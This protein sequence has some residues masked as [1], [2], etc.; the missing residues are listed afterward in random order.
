M[1]SQDIQ[2]VKA[3]FLTDKQFNDKQSPAASE[4]WF[5]KLPHWLK[6]SNVN[7]LGITTQPTA[8]GNE[9][10]F[11]AG[12]AFVVHMGK[13]A[14]G[15]NKNQIVY[16]DSDKYT[17]VSA[18]G[19]Y[20]FD[21]NGNMVVGT[22]TYDPATNLVSVNG[23]AGNYTQ[24]VQEFTYSGGSVTLGDTITVGEIGGGGG[25]TYTTSGS[26]WCYDFGN[27]IVMQGGVAYYDWDYYCAVANFMVPMKNTNYF[28]MVCLAGYSYYTPYPGSKDTTYMYVNF[29]DSYDSIDANY[30]IIGEKA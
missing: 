1:S 3:H 27:G 7:C 23:T 13:Y 29:T 28:P 19:A 17:T 22:I 16:I 4:L 24:M 30:M 14:D 11:Y 6:Y 12:A 21:A 2:K 5:V 25:G 9:I 10:D 8:S 15:T 20:C 18:S 26:S